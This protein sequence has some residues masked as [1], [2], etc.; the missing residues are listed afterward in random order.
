MN[1]NISLIVLLVAT[2]LFASVINSNLIVFNN[3]FYI[4]DNHR[5]FSGKVIE[6]FSN[7]TSIYFEGVYKNGIKHGVWTYYNMDG[8]MTLQ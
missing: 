3:K 2:L 5:P 8:V 1:K 4:P 6:Y 7:G